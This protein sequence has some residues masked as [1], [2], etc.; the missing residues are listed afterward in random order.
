MKRVLFLLLFSCSAYAQQVA[1]VHI[2]AEFN[3]NNDWYG[4]DI[5]EK[6]K[7]YNGYIDNNPKISEKYSITKVPTLILFK[8]GAEVYRW[9]AG[10]DMTLHVNVKE[11]Q[12]KIDAL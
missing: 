7:V 9:E 10:L 11:V 12:Q 4:L 3:S 5:I 2:N 8:D 6:T 1:V